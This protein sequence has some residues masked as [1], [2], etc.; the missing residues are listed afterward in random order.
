[1][2]CEKLSKLLP[3]KFKIKGVKR[4]QSSKAISP[5]GFPEWLAAQK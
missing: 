5:Q 3:V 1:M 2:S 4:T